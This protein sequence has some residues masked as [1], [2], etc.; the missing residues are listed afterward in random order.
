MKVTIGKTVKYRAYASLIALLGFSLLMFVSYWLTDNINVLVICIVSLLFLTI[1]TLFHAYLYDIEISS[2]CFILENPF[3][4][5]V[6]I[7][8]NDFLNVKYIGQYLGIC[9]ISF[10]DNTNYLF[11]ID[12]LTSLKAAFKWNLKDVEN[13]INNLVR[14]KIV[15]IKNN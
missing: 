13:D 14:G 8:I 6:K 1:T 15:E 5:K 12:D 11:A 9:K 4:R 7:P 2:E 10:K 3:G